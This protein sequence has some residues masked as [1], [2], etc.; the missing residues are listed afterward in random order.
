M[1][2]GV[3]FDDIER[4][5]ASA[6]TP[7]AHRRAAETLAG[8]A[9]EPHRDDEATPADLLSAAAWHRQ[10]AGDGEAA[11]GLYRQAVSAGG[12]TSLDARCLL[13]AALLGAGLSEEAQQVADEVRRS[14]PPI[15]DVATMAENFEEV[16][17]LEQAHRWV[18]MGVN[19]IEL[20]D[21]ADDHEIEYLLNARQRIRRALGFPSDELDRTAEANRERHRSFP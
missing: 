19:R 18:V 1:R 9:Q 21:D 11:L 7:K 3:T 6:R 16:G 12:T 17:D 4:W 8:W 20:D 13:H 2:N 15:S 14:R 10:Q 5:E